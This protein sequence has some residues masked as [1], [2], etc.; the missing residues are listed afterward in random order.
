MHSFILDLYHPPGSVL[1]PALQLSAFE[2]S[3]S[4]FCTC[5]AHGRGDDFLNVVFI[6]IINILVHFQPLL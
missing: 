4:L 6:K 3:I 2:D 5:T 1:W